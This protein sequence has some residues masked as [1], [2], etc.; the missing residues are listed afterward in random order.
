MAW[1]PRDPITTLIR[2]KFIH[3][4]ADMGREGKERKENER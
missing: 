3:N 1:T 2:K 4:R